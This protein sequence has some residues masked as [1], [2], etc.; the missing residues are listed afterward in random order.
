MSTTNPGG[1]AP[2]PVTGP[3][4][5][6][7]RTWPHG[8]LDAPDEHGGGG[9]VNPAS[10]AAG[11][12][13]DAFSVRP[14]FA[15]PISVVVAVV[16]AV[17]CALGVFAYFATR[18]PD[19]MAH[20]AAKALNEEPHNQ[21]LERINRG[22]VKGV[23]QPRLEQLRE[24]TD[25]GRYTTQD[26]LPTKTNPPLVHADHVRPGP[27]TT[28][29]LYRSGAAGPDGVRRV[30]IDKVIDAAGDKAARDALFPVQ[31]NPVKISE[32]ER[33]N[34]YPAAGR[35]EPP[36]APKEEPKND[37]GKKDDTKKDDTKKDDAKKDEKK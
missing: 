21:R 31:P 28:P 23:D 26:P 13:P 34:Q 22:N 19:P 7:G 25:Q 27:E 4:P 3:T 10:I 2:K 6:E 29:D 35:I 5:G 17:V 14:I 37:E 33:F 12:E 16:V 32:S 18:T 15:V 24:M 11:H 30:P 36:A 8:G 20:P 1:D 9:G